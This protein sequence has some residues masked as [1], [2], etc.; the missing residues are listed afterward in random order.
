M[1]ADSAHKGEPPGT[2]GREEKGTNRMGRGSRKY[3]AQCIIEHRFWSVDCNLSSDLTPTICKK[4]LIL[5]Q[6]FLLEVVY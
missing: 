5:Q 2:Q 3:P 6:S 4:A 1:S